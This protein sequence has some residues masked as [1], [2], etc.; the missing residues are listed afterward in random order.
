MARN[1]IF[2]RPSYRKFA[3]QIHSYS[4]L[5][6]I[7]VVNNFIALDVKYIAAATIASFQKN[8]MGFDKI[9]PINIQSIFISFCA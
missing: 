9:F 3:L 2:K 7:F 4:R 5:C 1:I 6:G 8:L